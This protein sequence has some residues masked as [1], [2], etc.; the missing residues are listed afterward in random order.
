MTSFAA[1]SG[2]ALFASTR[3]VKIN[4][5]ESVGYLVCA[6]IADSL[7]PAP[8][9]PASI[10]RIFSASI[11][12]K[13][14]INFLA[15]YLKSVFDELGL[16]PRS[17]PRRNSRRTTECA[18]SLSPP[19][20]SQLWP[21]LEPLMRIPITARDRTGISAGITSSEIRLAIGHLAR[22]PRTPARP[23]PT[24][25]VRPAPITTHVEGNS[26]PNSGPA[27][28]GP[29]FHSGCGARRF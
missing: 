26:G 11:S 18:I 16:I 15:F 7:G 10:G 5:V 29:A 19:Q 9:A 14:N 4:L 1:A 20:Q 21:S 2:A 3:P 24:R 23:G 27:L 13:R 25:M 8:A 22:I 17:R 6:A 28:T 12:S